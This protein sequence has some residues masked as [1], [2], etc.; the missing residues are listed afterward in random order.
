M[1]F[2]STSCCRL[3]T[4]DAMKHCSI[5]IQTSGEA[6]Y[7]VTDVVREKLRQMTTSSG[8]LHPFLIHTS[9]ALLISEDWDP[10][11]REDLEAFFKVLVPRNQPFIRHTL[12]GE[13]DSPSHMKSALLQQHLACIVEEGTLILG[14]WQ[15]IFLAEFRDHPKKRTLLLKFQP[16]AS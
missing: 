2:D 15:G 3:C 10:T 1:K 4:L 7:S 6:L 11:A 14:Q 9:C 12:E 16:D 8:I 5:E 13:D